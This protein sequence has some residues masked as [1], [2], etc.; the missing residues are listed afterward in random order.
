MTM[1]MIK[2][3]VMIEWECVQSEVVIKRSLGHPLVTN[4]Y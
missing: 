4:R 2:M 1:T 3:S